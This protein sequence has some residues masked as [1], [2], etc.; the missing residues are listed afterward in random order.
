MTTETQ[1]LEVL[2]CVVKH[3]SC[4]KA[5]KELGLTASGVSRIIT[6][7]EDRLGVKLVHRTTRSIRLTEV[8]E[9]FHARTQQVLTDLGEAEDEARN[10]RLRP[11]GTLRVSAPVVF[12]QHYL[13]PLLDV[14]LERYPEMSID[15]SLVD[16]F[17]DLIHEGVDLAIRIGALSDS[18]LIARR[19]CTNQRV[20]VA[21][22]KYIAEHG[23]PER[24]RDLAQHD[25]LQF[26]G[27]ERR[28][29]RLFGPEGACQV[30]ISGR[31]VSNNAEVL[32]ASAKKGIGITFGATLAVG[33]A[34]HTGELV[35]VLADWVFEPTAIFVVY[36][37]ALKQSPK[38]RAAVEFLAEQLPEPPRWDRELSDRVP[39]F[40]GWLEQV[41]SRQS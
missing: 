17:V 38:V 9:A 41:T 36:P 13:V 16:R 39:G 32:A 5:A 33:S 28:H 6:R 24:P 37:S 20:L 31:V 40:Q 3:L 35:R 11:R 8:G 2:H 21:S 19:L 4:A 10:T 29:W 15:L 14:L 27:F 30:P 26:T 23:A 1:E 7:L 22:P 12:G 34:L 25:C 18:R